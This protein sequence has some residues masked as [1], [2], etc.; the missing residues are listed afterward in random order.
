MIFSFDVTTA[1]GIRKYSANHQRNH[2]TSTEANH[3]NIDRRLPLFKLYHFNL[4]RI[5]KGISFGNIGYDYLFERI[6]I[7]YKPWTV[8]RI[9]LICWMEWNGMECGI[10]CIF[11]MYFCKS[12]CLNVFLVVFDFHTNY[13]HDD[14]IDLV[15]SNEVGF[16]SMRTSSISPFNHTIWETNARTEIK[17][18]NR[19]HN[20]FG[21]VIDAKIQIVVCESNR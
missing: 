9:I 5:I 4:K 13:T 10:S 16:H 18:D 7:K 19:S 14:R 3:L 12:F 15:I 6:Q 17:V 20:I 11:W 8:N 1:F 21:N 2:G